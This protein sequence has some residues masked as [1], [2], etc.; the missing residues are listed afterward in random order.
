MREHR[1]AH[2]THSCLELGE[3][4]RKSLQD[5]GNERFQ[6]QKL[7]ICSCIPQ[8]SGGDQGADAVLPEIDSD[9]IIWTIHLLNKFIVLVKDE[10]IE[11]IMRG[12]DRVT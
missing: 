2:S 10:K 5:C 1:L 7:W 3:E 9:D 6:F 11:E 12:A 4:I 8:E